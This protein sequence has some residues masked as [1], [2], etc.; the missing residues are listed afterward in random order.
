VA[1]T[2]Q[3]LRLIN[4]PPPSGRFGCLDGLRGYLALSVFFMHFIT[5]YYWKNGD[6]WKTVPNHT[7]AQLGQVGVGLFFM[8]TGFLFIHKIITAGSNINWR[9]L[10][11]SRIFRIYPLYILALGFVFITSYAATDWWPQ[12]GLVDFMARPLSWLL[13]LGGPVNGFADSKLV[14]AGVHWTLRYELL[15]YLSLPVLA[16]FINRSRMAAFMLA[17]GV[18]VFAL[19]PVSLPL[20][21]QSFFLFF[22]SGGLVAALYS[23]YPEKM[24]YGRSA[25]AA[26]ISIAALL[27]VIMVLPDV[28]SLLPALLIVPFFYCVVSGNT[29]GGLLSLKPSVLLGEVSFSLYLMHGVVLY[30]LFSVFMP[31]MATQLDYT[32]YLMLAPVVAA[33]VAAFSILTYRLIEK[34]AIDWNKGRIK[35]SVKKNS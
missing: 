24:V 16:W 4:L 32:Q 23:K 34:P 12:T 25:A 3:R 7:L 33:L 27:L 19:L 26:L 8:I 35:G 9:Q 2:A 6:G 22:L 1:F 15:F 21:N 18:F 10:Y 20:I 29:F 14:I 31:D 13:F 11:A 5:T 17:I 30:F 28:Y